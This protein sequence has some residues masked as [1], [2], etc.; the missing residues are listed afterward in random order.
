LIDLEPE[1][2][3][4]FGEVSI[5]PVEVDHAVPAVGFILREKGSA[6]VVS[7]DTGPTQRIWDVAAKI[8]DIKGFIVEVA[9]P[10]SQQMIADGAKHFT[11]TTL[12]NELPK[13]ERPN[14]PIGLYHLKPR[15]TEELLRELKAL[16]NPAFKYLRNGEV[17]RQFQIW[18][19][20]GWRGT[21]PRPAVASGS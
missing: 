18:T 20:D 17:L 7:G 13:F 9:F 12:R 14:I 6:V 8:D 19:L 16:G 5:Q 4:T 10:T 15:Y 1:R 2:I 3:Y 11:P 21:W